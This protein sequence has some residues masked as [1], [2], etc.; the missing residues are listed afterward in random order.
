MADEAPGDIAFGVR[1]FGKRGP[2]DAA[3]AADGRVD[4]HLE[5][6]SARAE[7]DVDRQVAIGAETLDPDLL[8]I[9]SIRSVL[10]IHESDVDVAARVGPAH[11]V[12]PALG[13]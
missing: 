8:K 9:S 1:G 2:D 10:G 11:A 5:I 3:S 7:H 6:R 12:L 4:V 13:F